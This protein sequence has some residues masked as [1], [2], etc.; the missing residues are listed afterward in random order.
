[1]NNFLLW[2][3]GPV[4]D[5]INRSRARTIVIFL[6]MIGLLSLVLQPI[7]AKAGSEYPF[8]LTSIMCFV[9]LALYK[10]TSN[11]VL[12]GNLSVFLFFIAIFNLSFHSGGIFSL[13]M[14]GQILVPILALNVVGK[15]S[16]II[17]TVVCILPILYHYYLSLDPEIMKMYR[18]QTLAYELQYYLTFQISLLI[19]P[20]ILVLLFYRLNKALVE[21]V[22]KSNNELDQANEILANRTTQLT[23]TKTQLEKSNNLLKKY[24]H[25]TSHD[26]KQPIRTIASFTQLLNREIKNENPSQAKIQDY[27]KNINEG[28]GRMNMQVE[29]ILEY[30]KKNLANL[31]QAI[32]VKVTIEQVLSDLKD[33]IKDQ[34]IKLSIFEMPIIYGLYSTIYKIFQNLI[35]NS[36]KYK[37]PSRELVLYIKVVEGENSWTFSVVDNGQGISSDKIDHI[38]KK[39]FQVN[40]DADGLGIGLNTVKD[41]VENRG[42]RIWVNSEK[43]I[44]S[45]FYFTYPKPSSPII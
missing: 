34:K 3:T 21:E 22:R 9:L 12:V 13:D 36:I 40:S 8:G 15:K 24:A 39:G 41:L 30:S 5:L 31:D 42:G 23:S 14:A 45:S 32:D 17:W 28:A 27:L 19:L 20:M 18:D 38:F 10:L 7:G 33:Q 44:G 6:L 35:S 29:E 43:D 11:T 25:A 16:G 2:L 26:L 37:D 1:M 4:D